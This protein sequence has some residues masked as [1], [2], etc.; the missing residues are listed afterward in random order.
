M[1]IWTWRHHRRL[2]PCLVVPSAALLLGT[3]YL[4]YHYVI[5]VPFGLLLG[6]GA[7]LSVSYAIPPPV[8]S[9]P[10]PAG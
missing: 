7:A 4:Q 9:S 10:G 3:V 1:L 2:F 8:L 5:D 6:A